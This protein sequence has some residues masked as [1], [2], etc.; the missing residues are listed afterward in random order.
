[1]LSRRP[2]KPVEEPLFLDVDDM[3]DRPIKLKIRDRT[4]RPLLAADQAHEEFCIGCLSVIQFGGIWHMWYA[5][6]DLGYEYDCDA[7]LC[8]A[9]SL[10]GVSWEKPGLGLV[11]WRDGSTDNNIVI[12]GQKI[13]ANATTVFLDEHA[14][15]SARVK[16]S[17]NHPD[18]GARW[19][20]GVGRFLVEIQE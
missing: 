9:R 11:P 19:A 13:R 1:V 15:A 3:P 6:Y 14:P 10:D 16:H 5:A 20:G 2:G 12:N 4:T 8:Y 18:K 7:F 17:Q